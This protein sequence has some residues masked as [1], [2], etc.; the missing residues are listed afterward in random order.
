MTS[1][2]SATASLTNRRLTRVMFAA[3]IPFAPDLDRSF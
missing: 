1:R 3:L 2:F